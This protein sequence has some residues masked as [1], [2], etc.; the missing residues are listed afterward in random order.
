M[1]LSWTP[2]GDEQAPFRLNF[3]AEI[4]ESLPDAGLLS[5]ADRSTFSPIAKSREDAI[6]APAPSESRPVADAP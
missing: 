4:A 6:F 1:P 2:N 3:K 5:L